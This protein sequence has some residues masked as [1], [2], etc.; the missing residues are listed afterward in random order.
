MARLER[1]VALIVLLA[2]TSL[3]EAALVRTPDA[4]EPA[5]A[6]IRVKDY[7]RASSELQ[8]LA[9]AG[10]ADAQYLLACLYLNRLAPAPDSQ[11]ARVWFSKAAGQGHKRAAAS[12]AALDRGHPAPAKVLTP[13]KK[14]GPGTVAV[15]AGTTGPLTDVQ[16]PAAGQRDLYAGW[17]DIAVA[18]ARG[19]ATLLATLLRRGANVNDTTPDGAPIVVVAARAQ[20]PRAVEVLLA[21]G[22]DA[23]RADKQADSAF[24]VTVRAGYDDVLTVLL[25]HGVKPGV[26]SNA[27]LLHALEA[28]HTVVARLLLNARIAIDDQDASGISPLMLAVQGADVNF[29]H[30]L[31]ESGA[32][33]DAEDRVGRTALWYAARAGNLDCA[34]S[35]L[36][37]GARLEH[38]DKSGMTALAAAAGAGRAVVL[39]FLLSRHAQIEARTK[40]GD[41]ALLLAAS[42]GH[43]DAVDK[44]LAAR[45]D[46]NA[47]NEFGDT[48]L[49]V[50]SRNGDAALVR[51]LLEAGASTRLRNRDRASAADIAAAR[52]F[53][54]VM[55]LLR[56]A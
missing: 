27:A 51:R 14:L 50:A 31:L 1:T 7:S 15:A 11:A 36:E 53:P 34:R 4:L 6:A 21:S 26:H 49:I 22:A 30:A 54:A 46:R 43:V 3:G 10:N 19:D 24:D 25:A 42:G 41:T 56:G 33:V 12:L 52:N 28:K 48:A 2:L 55:Q 44:L 17:P 18:A 32:T 5:K 39:D 29:V 13:L 23:G 40:R 45:A 16:H 37:H 20:A 35:L 9:G 47:Q 38:T 8:K